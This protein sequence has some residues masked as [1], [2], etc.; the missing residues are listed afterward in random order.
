MNGDREQDPSFQEMSY[1][2]LP[3]TL[4]YDALGSFPQQRTVFV[5]ISS[6]HSSSVIL[7]FQVFFN[8]ISQ[9]AISVFTRFFL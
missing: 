2:H 6:S 4:R 9:L 1:L 3:V 7:T 5:Q 8:M